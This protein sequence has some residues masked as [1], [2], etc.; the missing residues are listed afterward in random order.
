M[1]NKILVV[2]F[3][4]LELRALGH[5]IAAAHKADKIYFPTLEMNERDAHTLTGRYM[6][7]PEMQELPPKK[8]RLPEIV[9]PNNRHERRKQK[10]LGR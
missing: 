7:E 3:A 10:K 9:V 2:D 1:T 8:L 4:K 5:M 6:S